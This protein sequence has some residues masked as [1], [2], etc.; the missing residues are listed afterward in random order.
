M[1]NGDPRQP[2]R[3]HALNSSIQVFPGS[4][5]IRSP[6]AKAVN[7]FA[8]DLRPQGRI[9]AP[10]QTGDRPERVMHKCTRRTSARRS[11]NRLTCEAAGWRPR[12]FHFERNDKEA[13]RKQGTG[14]G[15]APQICARCARELERPRKTGW[16]APMTMGAAALGDPDQWQKCLASRACMGNGE[17]ERAR[18]VKKP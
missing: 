17:Q 3:S 10:L 15:K 11:A 14:R 9:E 7:V 18:R 5:S 1:R 16:C 6:S 4:E 13:E 2:A 12:N 8:L